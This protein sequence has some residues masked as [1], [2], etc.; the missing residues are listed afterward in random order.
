MCKSDPYTSPFHSN[1][2]QTIPSGQLRWSPSDKITVC[3][4][5]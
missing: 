4:R 1:W 3:L 2:A 5:P